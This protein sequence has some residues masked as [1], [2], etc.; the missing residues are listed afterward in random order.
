MSVKPTKS[1]NEIV[2]LIWS[3]PDHHRLG[4]VRV[5]QAESGLEAAREEFL[6]G[7]LSAGPVALVQLRIEFTKKFQGSPKMFQRLKKSLVD[8]GLVRADNLQMQL[9]DRPAEL[10]I[11]LAPDHFA[12]PLVADSSSY[13]HALI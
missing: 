7:L 12:L 8:R 2:P 13:G 5:E 4:T 11:D 6:L 9:S 1:R 10:A 3:V